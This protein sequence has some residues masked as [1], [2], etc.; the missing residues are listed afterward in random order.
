[1][2][3]LRALYLF[4]I[5]ERTSWFVVDEA[6][7]GRDPVENRVDERNLAHGP[8]IFRPGRLVGLNASSCC[9]QDATILSS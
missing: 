2:E 6:E 7:K 8:G 3:P 1:M 5:L 4:R 9:G